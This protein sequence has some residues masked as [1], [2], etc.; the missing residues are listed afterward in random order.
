ML[1][2]FLSVV[3]FLVL[4]GCSSEPPAWKKNRFAEVRVTEP[5][6]RHHLPRGLWKMIRGVL[7]EE[8]S[9]PASDKDDG[10]GSPLPSIFVP[11]KVYF[12]E[13]NEGILERGNTVVQLA[14]GGGDLDLSEVIRDKRGSFYLAVE[15]LP[16]MEDVKRRVFFLSD[17]K[18]RRIDAD[19][20]GAGCD[21]YFD[22][23]KAFTRA[24]KKVG[25]LLNTSDGRHVSALAGTYFFAAAKGD[26]LYL[27]ALRIK[28][29]K[30]KS[31]QCHPL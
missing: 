30:Y 20:V 7:Y 5:L 10:Y 1:R 18:Q 25:F 21:V 14:A 16:E 17:G 28:D 2:F 3:T 15:F 26:K 8:E 31:L 4:V 24:M 29:S 6:S 19:V 22:I 13:K 9:D 11:L 27:S 12:I 23:S